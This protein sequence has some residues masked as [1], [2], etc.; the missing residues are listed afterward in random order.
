MSIR[1]LDFFPMTYGRVILALLV[2]PLMTLLTFLVAVSSRR[3]VM[4][5]S[6]LVPIVFVLYAP[7]AYL[8]TAILGIPTFLVFRALGWK[9]PYAFILAGIIIGL[10]TAFIVFQFFTAWS[11]LEG[12]YIWCA[13]AGGFSAFVFWGILYGF[14]SNEAMRLS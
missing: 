12:D 14:K 5:L 13:M 11:V 3:G 2:S 1:A 7:F 10:A 4:P 8:A 6:N 9:N